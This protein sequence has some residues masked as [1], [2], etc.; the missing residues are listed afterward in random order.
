[1]SQYLRNALIVLGL[2]ILLTA[3]GLALVMASPATTAAD[4]QSD[5]DVQ[6]MVAARAIV[7]GNRLQQTDIGWE[8]VASSAVPAG[9]VTRSDN[10]AA[11]FVG[12]IALR[13]M[14]P[15][16]LLTEKSL[17]RAPDAVT[18]AASLNA[19]WRAVTIAATAAQT[20]AGMLLP[21]D[22]VDLLLSSTPS[23]GGGQVSVALPFTQSNGT[24][25]GVTTAVI[26]NVRI[27]AI[28]GSTKAEEGDKD[29]AK[30]D[31]E[32]GGAVTLEIR[33]EQ[34]GMV[35]SAATSGQIA[36]SLR[37]RMD[38]RGPPAELEI[39]PAPSIKPAA[40]AAPAAGDPLAIPTTPARPAS[41]VT[42]IRGGAAQSVQ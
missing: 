12:A 3:G 18:L 20:S 28:N 36:I 22:R 8:E 32:D 24:A 6:I 34:V 7:A 17:G 15:G 14:V 29:M 38:T 25:L 40:A 37:S 2:T 35:L 30:S 31:A 23:G 10:S 11:Q 4:K 33:P 13:N 5:R 39:P 42:I 21:G 27:I 41:S 9:A 1:M 26:T 16:E 19:G